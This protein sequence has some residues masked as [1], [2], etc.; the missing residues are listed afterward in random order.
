MKKSAPKYNGWLVSDE[1]HKRALAA[2]GY[3][4]VGSFFV[5]ILVAGAWAVLAILA[6]IFGMLAA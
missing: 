2:W 6:W 1:F 5:M 3:A 4:T